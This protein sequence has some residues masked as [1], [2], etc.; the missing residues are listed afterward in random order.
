MICRGAQSQPCGVARADHQRTLPGGRWNRRDDLLVRPRRTRP[1]AGRQSCAVALP[2]IADG[3]RRI[4]SGASR[5]AAVA[6]VS[7]SRVGPR[8]HG[9]VRAV[10]VGDQLRPRAR[11]G[12]DGDL[13]AARSR[14]DHRN[15]VPDRPHPE[16]RVR[17]GHLSDRG[18]STRPVR[19]RTATPADRRSL[20]PVGGQPQP[21]RQR[22]SAGRAQCGGPDRHAEQHRE[23]DRARRRTGPSSGA[24]RRGSRTS[25]SRT[26]AT[27]TT[28][29]RSTGGHPPGTTT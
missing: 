5:S 22:R 4:A 6:P 24:V 2:L 8:L 19:A 16:R 9:R 15:A 26:T 29:G 17:S 23:P 18:Q 13:R 27:E 21:G 12:A 1:A 10:L 28:S 11:T 20:R 14:P 3:R 7:P 25:A